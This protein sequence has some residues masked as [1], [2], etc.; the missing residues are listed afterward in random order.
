MEALD[1]QG[2]NDTPKVLLDAENEVFEISGRSL[3]EDVVNFYKPV[4][5]WLDE[6]KENPK[7]Y[8]EFVFRYIYF[9]TATSKLI[10][11]IIFKLEAMY[12]EGHNIQIMWFYED[13]DE[14]MQDVGEEFQE[15]C[16]VP[17]ELVAY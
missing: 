15:L 7:E 12:E 11:D 8:T 9:N 10:Q 17:F 16:D 5:D 3:P 2:T 13:E 14:D 4:L 1:I 6:Y